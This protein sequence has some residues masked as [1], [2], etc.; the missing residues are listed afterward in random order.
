[1]GTH[2]GELEQIRRRYA[3]RTTLP[4]DR[5]SRWKPDVLARVHERQLATTALLAANGIHSMAGLDILEVGC[6]EGANLIEFLQLG[7][8]PDRLVGNDLLGDRIE[9]ARRLLPDLVR[10]YP[11]DA[12]ALVLA[13]ASFDIVYQSTVFSS[14][15]DDALQAHLA[16]AMWRWLRP[17]GAV[18]W[19][20]FT[21]DNPRNP[22]VRG[23]PLTRIRKL[24]PAGRLTCRRV[25][26]AP[27]LARAVTRVHPALYTVFNMLPLLRTHVLCWIHKA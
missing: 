20:D 11:G 14:I 12:S 16:A 13:D 1:M 27:P 7:A 18:L 6:G 23:V 8:D 2:D 9:R 17:G 10:F 3:S 15:L 25:T 21:V 4:A 5:Y 19:Y 26:L 24:F 22:D